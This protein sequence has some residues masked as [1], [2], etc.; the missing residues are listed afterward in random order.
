M[1]PETGLI[2][3]ELTHATLSVPTR[4]LEVIIQQVLIGENKKSGFVGIVL[5]DHV[6]VLE[7]NVSY[8][9]HHYHTDVLSFSLDENG[10]TVEGEVYVDMDTAY[11]RHA[12]FNATFVEEVYRYAVHGVLHL[13]AYTDKTTIKKAAMHTFENR[14]LGFHINSNS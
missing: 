14:Y 10:D 11:E 12:E 7:L 9:S 4:P 1:A 13:V 6:S 2:S 5:T 8:L 3:I